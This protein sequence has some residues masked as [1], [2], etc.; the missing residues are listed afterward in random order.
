MLSNQ[1]TDRQN[2][3]KLI[4]TCSADNA[5]YRS[6]EITAHFFFIYF[7]KKKCKKLLRDWTD[8]C[9][10]RVRV[11]FIFSSMWTNFRGRCGIFAAIF[12]L[13]RILAPLKIYCVNEPSTYINKKKNE[14]RRWESRKERLFNIY[15]L[16]MW[17][18][19]FHTRRAYKMPF[20]HCGVND[21]PGMHDLGT[22]FNQRWPIGV[23]GPIWGR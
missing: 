20:L 5:R 19:R 21:M 7:T 11:D 9:F 10:R 3:R 2:V 18:E 23:C 12:T 4:E 13:Q 14:N 15:L 1:Q 8:W 22:N 17:W 6:F 16:A